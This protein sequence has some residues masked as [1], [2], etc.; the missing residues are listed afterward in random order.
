MSA[1]VC[2]L[3]L[4]PVAECGTP[5]MYRVVYGLCAD[6]TVTGAADAAT[7]TAQR[8]PRQVGLAVPRGVPGARTVHLKAG[9]SSC[10]P[11]RKPATGTTGDMSDSTWP[12]ILVLVLLLLSP[13]AVTAQVSFGAPPLTLGPSSST[14]AESAVMPLCPPPLHLL[15][16]GAPGACPEFLLDG[17]DESGLSVDASPSSVRGPAADYG[18]WRTLIASLTVAGVVAGEVLTP[19]AS[20]TSQLTARSP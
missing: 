14:D 17:D 6:A 20:L 10:C 4:R 5:S 16:R 1:A 9:R 18:K 7:S 11:R 13:N 3:R 8:E 12:T 19:P 2:W 15:S